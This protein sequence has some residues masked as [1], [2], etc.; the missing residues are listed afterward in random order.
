MH[1][2]KQYKRI[3][4]CTKEKGH[5]VRCAQWQRHRNRDLALKEYKGVAM[6]WADKSMGKREGGK[7]GTG[8]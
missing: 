3:V 7:M 6:H 2:A 8:A 1:R 5:R 4:K